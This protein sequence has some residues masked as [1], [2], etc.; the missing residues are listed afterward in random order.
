MKQTKHSMHETTTLQ[1]PGEKISGKEKKLTEID[2]ETAEKYLGNTLF[3]YE[4][5]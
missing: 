2:Y 1:N 5:H 4:Q 3:G